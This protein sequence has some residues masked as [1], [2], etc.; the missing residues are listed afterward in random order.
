MYYVYVLRS[1]KDGSL[2]KGYT[3]DLESRLNQHNKG[4]TKSTSRKIPWELVYYEEYSELHDALKR[5]K[6]FKSSAG[7]RYIKSKGIK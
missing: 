6:Y 3:T 4:K 2:Y 5:E 1:L 7:R